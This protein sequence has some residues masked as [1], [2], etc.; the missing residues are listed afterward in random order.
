VDARLPAPAP[1]WPRVA[2]PC[3]GAPC[4]CPPRPGACLPSRR[5]CRRLRARAIPGRGAA[6]ASGRAGQPAIA[7]RRCCRGADACPKRRGPAARSDDAVRRGRV[8]RRPLAR[9]T[10]AGRTRRGRSRCHRRRRRPLWRDGG[11]DAAHVDDGGVSR[12]LGRPLPCRR[13]LGGRCGR[14]VV[15]RIFGQPPARPAVGACCGGGGRDAVPPPAARQTGAAGAARG[16]ASPPSGCFSRAY[17]GP[18]RAVRRP[19]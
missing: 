18:N 10:A 13:A 6:F 8:S 2:E 7:S 1:R 16:D 17:R 19:G 3:P 4:R 11:G 9:S 12:G 5:W 15:A 14:S